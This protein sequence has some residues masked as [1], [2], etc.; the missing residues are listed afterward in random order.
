MEHGEHYLQSKNVTLKDVEV[1]IGKGGY[2]R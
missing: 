1:N 2:H